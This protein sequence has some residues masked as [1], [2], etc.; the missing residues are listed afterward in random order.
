MPSFLIFLATF[1]S[2]S[3]FSFALD[4]RNGETGA[5]AP[6][7][8]MISAVKPG[9]TLLLGELHGFRDVAEVQVQILEALR[10]SGHKVDVAFEFFPYT[11]QSEVDQFTHGLTPESDFLASIGW[12]KGMDFGFY[13]T[14]VRFSQYSAGE[15]T[16]A[17]NAPRTL[18]G[19]VAKRG[20]EGLTDEEKS[21]LPP[22]MELGRA[23]YFDRFREL[24]GGHVDEKALVRYFEAQSVWDDTMAWQ[25]AGHKSGNTK[26][27]IVGE[28]HV[29]YGGGLPH[30]LSVRDPQAQIVTVGFLNTHD[31]TA[32]ELESQLRPHQSWG[33]RENFI[34]LVNL[35]TSGW[36]LSLKEF[37]DSFR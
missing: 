30:R 27:V 1:L 5:P 11:K 24:M 32:E 35:P 26:V 21:L 6:L 29:Q 23:E 9:T 19:A 33:T 2:L 7:D 14:Q 13:R 25:L 20:L 4:C 8:S 28:F 22:N 34:C 18:T 16:L 36:V 12:G 15:R 10:N 37:R 3:Q 17:I 31:L